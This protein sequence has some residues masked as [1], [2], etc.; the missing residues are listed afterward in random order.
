LENVSDDD[1]INRAWKSIKE[2][3]K[4]SAKESLDL[5]GI[6]QHKPWFDEEC[7]GTLYQGEQ[8]KMQWIQDR[9]QS[10]VDN[11]NNVRPDASRHFRNKKKTYLKAK[12]EEL[13]THSKINNIRDLYRGINDFKKGYQPRTIIVEDEKSDLVADSHNIMARWRNSFSQILNIHGVIQLWNQLPAD[14]LE[15]LP[16]KQ[17]TFKKRARK[18]IIEVS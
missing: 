12:I 5:H 11:M 15:T 9:S 8:V 2:D 17:I 1:D 6:K 18:A 4:T 14:V 16:C 3:I 7:L 10:N 13:E